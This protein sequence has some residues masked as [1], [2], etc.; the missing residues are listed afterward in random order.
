MESKLDITKKQFVGYL[1]VVVLVLAAIAAAYWILP[2]KHHFLIFAAIFFIGIVAEL[3]GT[4]NK[5]K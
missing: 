4:R 2:E 5:N 3:V 1:L